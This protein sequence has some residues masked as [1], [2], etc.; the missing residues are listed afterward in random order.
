MAPHAHRG[1]LPRLGPVSTSL[2]S[3]QRECGRIWCARDGRRFL[4]L[5]VLSQRNPDCSRLEIVSVLNPREIDSRWFQE[6]PRNVWV[7]V[8]VEILSQ[9][10]SSSQRVSYGPIWTLTESSPSPYPLLPRKSSEVPFSSEG[11][12][13]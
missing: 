4:L 6:V 12:T 1:L 7:D 2:G 5:G 10:E 9:V 13:S 8:W 11:G 3:R